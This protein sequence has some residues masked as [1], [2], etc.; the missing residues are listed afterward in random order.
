MLGVPFN[1]KAREVFDDLIA[2]GHT[3]KSIC[4]SIFK[5][6]DKLAR[7]AGDNRF[8]SIFKNEILKWSWPIGDPRWE[9]YNQ[10]KK[11]IEKIKSEQQAYK[12]R[13]VQMRY[14][15]GIEQGNFD[16]YIYFIQGENGGSI[17]IGYTKDVSER[18]KALQT[19]HPDTLVCLDLFPG[20]M[21][22]ETLIHRDLRKYRIRPNGEWFKPDPYV[23]D[24]M[25]KYKARALEIRDKAKQDILTAKGLSKNAKRKLLSK[26]GIQIE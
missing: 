2:D 21:P 14:I 19:G 10:R 3:E 13:M 7:F 18:I 17:K 15:N 20:S 11:V 26:K 24:R 22:M 5:T 9:Q 25:K 4:F 1:Q 23:L 8:W 16:G 12:D 6:Y